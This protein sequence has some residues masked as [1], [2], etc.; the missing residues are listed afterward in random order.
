LKRIGGGACPVDLAG[1]DLDLD[2]CLEQRRSLQV[3]VR[4]PLLG[5]D[6][7][8]ALESLPDRRGRPRGVALGQANQRES[9]LGVPTR[10]LRREQCLL[11]TVGVS[12]VQ[13]DPP[14][15]AERPVASQRCC[16]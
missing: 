4:R 3:V 9:G 11:G 7:Q 8:G 13:P 2:L 10:P 12:A 1:G 5:R 6:P 15:L 16:K 14:Q